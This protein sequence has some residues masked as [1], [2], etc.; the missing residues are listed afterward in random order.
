MLL[1]RQPSGPAK[2]YRSPQRKRRPLFLGERIAVQVCPVGPLA[3][4]DDWLLFVATVE[5][6]D[7][8]GTIHAIVDADEHQHPPVAIVRHLLPPEVAAGHRFTCEFYHVRNLYPSLGEVIHPPEPW[9]GKPHR[10]AN[11]E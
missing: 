7:D 9:E 8:N 1:K 2:D 5:R 4:R 3:P 10:D 6:I 11:D